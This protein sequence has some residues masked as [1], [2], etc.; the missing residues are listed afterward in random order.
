MKSVSSKIS[1]HDSPYLSAHNT[2]LGNVL[3]QMASTY[4]LAKRTG[5]TLNVHRLRLYC[6]RLRASFGYDHDRTIFRNFLSRFDQSTF[7]VPIPYREPRNRDGNIDLIQHLKN[8]E[9]MHVE[10]EGY[11]EYFHYFHLYRHELIELFAPDPD[12]LRTIKTKYGQWL[13][14]FTPISVHYRG[15]PE[16]V[17]H[18]H[19][20]NLPFYKQAVELLCASVPDAFFFVFSDN[21]ECVDFS[22]FSNR[23]CWVEGNPDYI[24]L[25]LI[26]M[27]QH[28]I[29]SPSTFNWWG[30]YLGYNPEKGIIHDE[31]NQHNIFWE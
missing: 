31:N 14:N 12:S 6:D 24:D 16:F 13:H 26:G 23:Y 8:S 9:A 20:V 1:A 22:I 3:F 28:H 29:M 18:H 21:K 7:P 30:V 5:R 11:L 25:W 17:A 4:A 15:G 2:G 27:C 19:L 10:I